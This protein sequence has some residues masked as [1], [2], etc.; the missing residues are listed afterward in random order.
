M[1]NY[2]TG[3]LGIILWAGIVL[4]EPCYLSIEQAEGMDQHQIYP[5]AEA[6]MN[7]YVTPIQPMPE[8]GIRSND[9]HYR[10]SIIPSGN[11][12]M[13]TFSGKVSALGNSG[14]SGMEGVTQ[15][16]LRAV[17]G[18]SN[19]STRSSLC[20]AYPEYFDTRCSATALTTEHQEIKIPQEPASVIVVPRDDP[21][22]FRRRDN[23][24]PLMLD[25]PKQNEIPPQV[26]KHIRQLVKKGRL[27]EALNKIE[28]K[29]KEHPD[30]PGLLFGRAEVLY[31][32]NRPRQARDSAQR[33]CE[34]GNKRACDALQKLK[35]R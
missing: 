19:D 10:L 26:E 30:H 17:Y 5:I 15:A 20:K 7:Q 4:A 22:H 35:N 28:E 18:I 34:L 16:I 23:P 13:A 3:T 1:M 6:L 32:M 24:S 27:D 9:C 11:S 33:A 29:L 21:Q 12:I 31:Q 14:K 25:R 2:T 8:A